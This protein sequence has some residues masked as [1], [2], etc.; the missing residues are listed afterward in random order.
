MDAEGVKRL[1]VVDALGRIVGVV[2]RG[3]LLKVRLRADADIRRDVV[4]CVL[5]VPDGRVSSTSAT[6]S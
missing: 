5:A 4:G 6:A 1:P 2:S 3:D